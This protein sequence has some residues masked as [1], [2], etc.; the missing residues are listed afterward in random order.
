MFDTV[1]KKKGLKLIFIFA[2]AVCSKAFD[3][4]ACFIGDEIV[5]FG[6]NGADRSRGFV[7]EKVDPDIPRIVV[8]EGD[9]VEILSI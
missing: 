6:E 1:R 2:A 7:L 9:E 3:L 8:D 5:P 4:T